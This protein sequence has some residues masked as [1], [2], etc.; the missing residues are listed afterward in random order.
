MCRLIGL[1]VGARTSKGQVKIIVSEN[2][3]MPSAGF[4]STKLVSEQAIC[5]NG[6]SRQGRR[7]EGRKDNC[8]R[9]ISLVRCCAI[10]VQSSSR[11]RLQCRSFVRSQVQRSSFLFPLSVNHEEE[12][13]IG[14]GE[15]QIFQPAVRPTDR[16][17]EV[18]AYLDLKWRLHSLAPLKLHETVAP[19]R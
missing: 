18:T 8:P 3:K 16:P 13:N 15:C 2:R 12:K 19:K 7:E 10:G 5:D 17:T 14:E 9:G 1:M 6:P 4:C 11:L